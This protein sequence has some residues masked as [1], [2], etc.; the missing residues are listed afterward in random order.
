MLWAAT[1]RC[2]WVHQCDS[3]QTKGAVAWQML[4]FT[5]CCKQARHTLPACAANASCTLKRPTFTLQG[6]SHRA[7]DR[8]GA[9]R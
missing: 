9:K 3:V 5:C 4:R 8:S 1:M 6:S 7:D 2:T